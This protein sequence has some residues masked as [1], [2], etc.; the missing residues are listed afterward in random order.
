M[1]ACTSFYFYFY[2][3]YCYF[4][5][6]KEDEFAEHFTLEGSISLPKVKSDPAP[7]TTS[8]SKHVVFALPCVSSDV[9]TEQNCASETLLDGPCQ[10]RGGLWGLGGWGGWSSYL[11]YH[12]SPPLALFV[13]TKKKKI[14]SLTGGKVKL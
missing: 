14:K 12:S 1:S 9:P 8:C 11:S 7:Q 4:S 5:N 10:G 13:C 2:Y 3:Y 6:F